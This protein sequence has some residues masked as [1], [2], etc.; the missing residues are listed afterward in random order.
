MIEESY[1]LEQK[2][3]SSCAT[4][5]EINKVLNYIETYFKEDKFS[6]AQLEN[7]KKLS[8]FL[9]KNNI[10][11]GELESETLLEKSRKLNYMF[12][13]LSDESLLV[14]LN[15]YSNM[16]TLL[17]IYCQKNNVEQ[18][19]DLEIELYNRDSNNDLDLFKLYLTEIGQYKRLTIEEERSLAIKSKNG[20]IDARNKL[21]EHNLRLVI[22]I[23][24]R[25][26]GLG[27]S[28]YD[29]VL[30][31]NEGITL[32]S[33]KFDPSRNCRFST[34]ATWWIKQSIQKG[35]RET[36]RTIV[37]PAHIHENIVR[38]KRLINQYMY[39]NNGDYPSDAYLAE[40]LNLSVEKIRVI[41][42]NMEPIVSLSTPIGDEA[43]DGTLAD[44]IVDETS[45]IEAT[46][47]SMDLAEIATNLLNSKKLSDKEREIVKMRL[48]Y[49]GEE[50]TLEEIGK[51]Y[52]L[53]R[54]RIRQIE[55]VALKKLLKASRALKL[56][57]YRK[58]NIMSLAKTK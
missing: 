44:M 47:D 24:K 22:P 14:R 50:M 15:N 35:I 26:Q 11:I 7:V 46:I 29:L 40:A 48:G 1:E 16:V 33:N 30:C 3:L 45:I 43:K 19:A 42:R 36:G 27:L 34:Y 54:E 23:A 6:S 52:N 18:T 39:D 55:K 8:A 13:K 37:I 12:Q 9:S 38:V 57:K 4:S 51:I 21:V 49:Y 5:E 20:D 32:A 17:D 53:S 41:K 58:R 28:L 56:E 25:Y 10:V 2:D 31:G